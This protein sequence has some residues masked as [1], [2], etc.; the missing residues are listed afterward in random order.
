MMMRETSAVAIV[1]RRY[2]RG[3]PERRLRVAGY[4][5]NAELAR[6]IR[7]ARMAADIS[8][9]ELAKILGTTQSCISRL[10]DCDYEGSHSIRVLLK[11]CEALGR[12]LT[13]R[14]EPGPGLARRTTRT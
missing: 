9:Q 11:V 13:V 2:L 10:E 1:R 5:L 8:Q 4:R 12:R 7:L 6:A 14:I 3:D